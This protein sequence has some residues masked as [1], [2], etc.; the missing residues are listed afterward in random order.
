M[1]RCSLLVAG[2]EDGRCHTTSFGEAL[3][4]A[5]T[6][7]SSDGITLRLLQFYAGR[8]KPVLYESSWLDLYHTSYF[9]KHLALSR[10]G[11]IQRSFWKIIY[12]PQRNS[13]SSS[14]IRRSHIYQLKLR[15]STSSE[16]GVPASFIFV[17]RRR[18]SDVLC[19]SLT[20]WS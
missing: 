6:N 12:R 13:S 3:G 5:E 4:G 8:P 18:R 7:T 19:L 14:F 10:H 9:I 2:C 1:S 17:L 15:T 11:Q 20:L 16:T